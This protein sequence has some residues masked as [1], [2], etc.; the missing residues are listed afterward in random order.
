MFFQ[1]F[2]TPGLG[3]FSYAIGCPA[4]GEL[5]II[6]PR[7]D[8]EIY[9]DAAYQNNMKITHIFDTHVHADHISGTQE[10]QKATKAPIY[11]HEKADVAYKN[12]KI[13]EGDT[14]TLGS[15]HLKVLHTPGHTPNSIS[16]LVTDLARST[17]PELIL[18]GDV[19]FVGD[20]GRPDLPG[21]EI[22]DQQVQDLYDSLYKTLG[23]LPDGLEVYPAHGQG[24]LCGRN[25]SP[26]TSSTLGYERKANPMLRCENFAE[27]KKKILSNMP[28]RPQSF[29]HI[30]ATNIKGAP[31]LEH[32]NY[33]NFGLTLGELDNAVSEKSVVIDTRDVI[34]FAGAHIPESL[35]VETE[36]AQISNWLGTII[37]P[38][39]S[40][41]LILKRDDDFAKIRTEMHRVGYDNIRGFLKGG[42]KTW[43]SAGRTFNSLPLVTSEDL[44][45]QLDSSE[46]PTLVDVRSPAEWESYHIKSSIHLPI[47]ILASD[48]NACFGFPTNDVVVICQTGYRSN[49]AASLFLA[50][51]CNKIHVLAG[52]LQAWRTKHRE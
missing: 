24:S 4:T 28:M 46:P 2:R 52:G 20:V 26:K 42:I 5:A 18:T 50:S 16:L 21:S 12:V 13:K 11:I 44:K 51:K 32:T 15:A 37:P 39:S 43:V 22:M 47:D 3:C 36:D 48:K 7:R 17:E 41:I 49:M 25:M 31:L 23:S 30:I 40:I 14:F 45:H 27:F 29:S 10:L 34:A 35:N 1:Q 38:S 9:L 33:K 19:L 6:D 8:I